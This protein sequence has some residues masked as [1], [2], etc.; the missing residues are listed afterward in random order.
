[1]KERPIN[2][3]A[4][5]VRAIREG[6]KTQFR[7]VARDTGLY[8]IDERFHGVDVATR[9]RERLAMRCPFGAPGARLWVRE[10]TWWRFD[11]VDDRVFTGYVADGDPVRPGTHRE[12]MMQQ[13]PHFRVPSIHMPREMSRITLEVVSAK[14]ERL[15]D[16]SEEDAT[17]EGYKSKSIMENPD[18]GR[19]W[20]RNIWQPIHGPE[21]WEANPWVWVVEFK[22]VEGGAK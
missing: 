14:V 20:F 7:R 2:L 12:A 9:E 17:A 18:A 3:K 15:Q 11:G 1:M 4:E 5:E 19:L 10:T 13:G 16:I 21:S 6:R 8:A 22:V